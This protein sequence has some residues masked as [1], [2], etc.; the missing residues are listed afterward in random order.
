[1]GLFEYK[2]ERGHVTE[3][4]FR[5]KDVVADSVQCACG[6]VATKALPRIA[7]TPGRWGESVATWNEGLGCMVNGQKDID[8]ICD[9]RGLVPL[10]DLPSDYMETTLAR[11]VARD[12]HSDRCIEALKTADLR[13]INTLTALDEVAP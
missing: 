2:C 8:R 7:R 9:E 3:E 12:A 4:L 11:Q 5:G 1:M 10:S 13:D 6:E